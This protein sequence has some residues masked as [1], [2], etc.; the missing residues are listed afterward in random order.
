MVN[1]EN[2]SPGIRCEQVWREISNY[3]EGD[4]E[5][6]LR[7]EMDQHLAGCPCCR[8]VLAGTRNVVSLYSDERMIDVP[9]G[10]SVR[11]RKR[12]EQNART[13]THRWSS[14][15]AWMVP[16]AA[17]LLIT[18]GIRAANSLTPTHPMKTAHAQPARQI[19]PD[20]PVIVTAHA[21]T[22][23]AAGC[24]FIHNKQTERILTAKEAMREGYEPC[25]RCMRKY[26]NTSVV[27]R[28]AGSAETNPDLYANDQDEDRDAA[29]GG[30]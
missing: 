15:Y 18:G 12:L 3:L 20:M 22:F 1:R 25:L 29:G 26:L 28:N 8:S 5:P 23:H 21:K 10:F 30:Q 24:P 2:N 19:P 6:S 16:V 14:W 11:L 7:Q 4:V 27:G 13:A 9:G 17:I